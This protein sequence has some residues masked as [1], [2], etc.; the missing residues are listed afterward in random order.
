MLIII[1]G[2]DCAR[3]TTLARDI[4]ARLAASGPDNT[5]ELL[6]RGPPGGHPLDEY[7]VPLLGYRPGRGHHIVCDRWHWG[8][9]VYPHVLKRATQLDLPMF[10]YIEMFLQSRGA[11]TVL[12]NPE[13]AELQDCI[14]E[15]GDDLV[16]VEQL[17][18][19]QM[20]YDIISDAMSSTYESIYPASM[21]P[22]TVIALARGKEGPAAALNMFITP[23]GSPAPDTILFGDVRNC[24]GYDCRH[25]TRHSQRGPAFMPYPGTSGHYLMHALEEYEINREYVMLANSC[26]VDDVLAL[27]PLSHQREFVALGRNAHLQL[28]ALQIKHAAAPHPQFI[29]RFHH[30]AA[31][32]YGKLI[33]GLIGTERNELTWRP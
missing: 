6:H 14:R 23:V 19:I 1:E 15:R 9:F 17:P 12:L 8:E 4:V 13:L 33:Q 20:R 7:V 32:S 22:D 28:T 25:S 11:I 16:N 26:D 18:E 27:T 10:R 29:R 30:A 24:S 5:V 2:P 31:S 3:K 21:T